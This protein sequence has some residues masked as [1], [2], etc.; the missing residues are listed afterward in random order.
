MNMRR[1]DPGAE[2]ECARTLLPR[3]LGEESVSSARAAFWEAAGSM[4]RY[5]S[6]EPR[7]LVFLLPT[8]IDPKL[9]VVG[10]NR[11]EFVVLERACAIL[12]DAGRLVGGE[13]IV[14]VGAHVGTSTIFALVH[15]GFGRAVAIEPDPDHLPLLRANLALNRVD[16]RVTVV[17]AAIADVGRRRQPFQQDRRTDGVYHWMKGRLV[18]EPSSS[19]VPVETM[20]LDALADAGVVSAPLTG[21]LWFDCAS[22]EQ[23]ALGSA[24]A[25]LERRVPLVFTVRR[26]QFGKSNPLLAHLQES[27]EHLVDLR[28]PGLDAPL[29]AWAPTFRRLDELASLPE[30]KKLTDV[31]VF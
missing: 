2:I 19:A 8:E 7:G 30:R 13:T 15:Q 6:V 14:D 16:E 1:T 25:F 22:C 24:F 17:G 12:R 27:Y 28:R 23:R 4:T 3:G 5:V 18:D 9:F 10:G 20:T 29:S 21:L 11:V 26:R 31:L